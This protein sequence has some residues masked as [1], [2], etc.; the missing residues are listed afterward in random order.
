MAMD[1]R[2]NR[3][4][5]K[6][7]YRAPII[8]DIVL[9]EVEINFRKQARI[10]ARPLLKLH[11]DKV[12]VIALEFG[13]KDAV[14][15]ERGFFYFDRGEFV[16]LGLLL[17]F[18][19]EREERFGK[20]AK[21]A[22]K[23]RIGFHARPP[24]PLRCSVI[25]KNI[26][27]S[28]YHSRFVFGANLSLPFHVNFLILPALRTHALNTRTQ[29]RLSRVSIA[30]RLRLVSA[31]ALVLFL[32]AL[33]FSEVHSSHPANDLPKPETHFGFR[34]GSDK[35]L[36]D[37][38]QILA[39]FKALDAASERVLLQN[40]GKTTE[41]ND[42]IV[43]FIS[44][45]ENLR[46]LSEW[47]NLQTRLAD[48]RKLGEQEREEAFKRGRSIVLINCA[49]HSTEVGATQMAPELAYYLASDNSPEVASILE[50]VMTL[51][52]PSHNPDGQLRVVNWYRKNVET[53]FEDAPLPELYHKYTGHDNNRDWF[54]FTQ[55]ETRLTVEKLYNA[56]HPH[57]TIDMH[58]MGSNG[59]RLFVPPYI[60][61]IEPNVDPVIV[62]LLNMLGTHVQAALT[63]QGK[64]GVVSNA[65]FDAWT[66]AR[67]Y[68][69][70]HGGLRFLTEVASARTASPIK[71]AAKD[72]RGG[73]GY[74]ARQVSWNFPLPWQGGEWKLRDIVDYDFAAAMTILQHAA[75][76]REFWLRSLFEVQRKAI[77]P[78][79]APAAFIIPAAQR[80]PQGLLDLLRILQL[81][82]VEIHF[83]KKDFAFEGGTAQRGD[84]V[85]R[86]D[87]PYGRFA[88]ALL[89]KQNYP[90]IPGSDGKPRIP[91][92]VTAHTLPLF[93]GVEV[94]AA[95][96]L[97][98]LDLELLREIDFNKVSTM[99]GDYFALSRSNNAS[100][101]AVN[102]LLRKGVPVFSAEQEFI[103]E[104]TTWP[105][106]TFI[107]AAEQ[108]RVVVEELQRN[109]ERL[110]SAHDNPSAVEWH[111]LKRNPSAKQKAV[112]AQRVGLYKSEIS[113]MDEGWTRFVLEDYGF[114]YRSVN[115]ARLRAESLRMSLDVI[116]FPDQNAAE[117]E[118]G[119]DD[120]EMPAEYV[121]GIGEAGVRNLKRFVEEGGTVL[122]LNEAAIF[123]IKKF[124]LRV[125][126]V[127][128][129][130]E[131]TSFSAPGSVLRVIAQSAHPLAHGAQREETIFFVDSPAF[132]AQEG[133]AILT[134]PP[135][136]LL[137]SGWLA[138]E[139]YLAE[140]TAMLEVPLG[141]GRIVLYGFR[142]QFRAQFRAS[143]KFL[144][145][146]LY[147]F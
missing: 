92:D 68:Q 110:T 103:D 57:V 89:E 36:A 50:N 100:F 82:A 102:M 97:P 70:Y 19:D 15:A 98:P 27:E 62:S 7:H 46:R 136:G 119:F 142:P 6:N 120:K 55:K 126:N 125:E 45:P 48:P 104:S 23:E 33:L 2:V 13:L 18:A 21:E 80:D 69:H 47:Q 114:E 67:A 65:I 16:L 84:Y 71:I 91:Y 1:A 78:K 141:K 17:I 49:I 72:L 34:L 124:W 99:R 144:F 96:K 81:G 44:T 75:L 118:D 25:D 116:I 105:V 59:A 35:K 109:P 121:G 107:V 117:I 133:N 101:H 5:G 51:L 29:E 93:L 12:E 3:A 22:M 122:A 143:Y 66:P 20:I 53:S 32:L 9:R 37:Y 131:R 137:L 140:R 88:K 52:V 134:Y 74:N 106:G 28:F 138:G 58:Q 94:F 76:N 112:H 86:M 10:K 87:Q 83:A 26:A 39:Y 85:I 111:M 95:A 113:N 42:F 147:S 139:N 4:F 61:P 60:D 127:V 31:P 73:M 146:A 38:H 130:V 108:Q 90:L 135:A 30:L 14:E 128:A 24:L 43:A 54:M 115:N 8:G 11:F 77:A 79:N 132:R 41:G 129:N 64:A 56:W 123:F 145:N 63:A 40:L